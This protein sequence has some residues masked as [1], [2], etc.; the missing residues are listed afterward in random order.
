M[1]SPRGCLP[2]EWMRT[3]PNDGLIHLHYSFKR[4]DLVA[5]N[6]QALQDIMSTNTYNFEKPCRLTLDI[7]GPVAMSCDFQSLLNKENKIADNFLEILNPSREKLIFLSVNVILPQWI[8][9]RIHLR[10]NRVIDQETGFLRA[11]CHDIVLEKREALKSHKVDTKA[12]EADIFGTIMLRGEFSDDE[13]VD[14]M[15]TF[16]AAGHETT[17]RALTWACYLLCQHPDIQSRLREE[18]YTT[19]PS[20]EHA[21]TWNQLES[22]SLLNGVC[23]EVLRLYPTVPATIRE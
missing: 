5:T 9:H 16:L 23:E 22:M 10:L 2:L 18:I 11:V 19:I 12:L 21:I 15:L 8:A 3:I 7:I 14:Q 20:A 13:L 4:S 17:A 6:H 1:D